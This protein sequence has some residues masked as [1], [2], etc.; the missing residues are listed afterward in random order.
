[1]ALLEATA[2]V[3]VYFVVVVDIVIAVVVVNFGVVD[4][5]FLVAQFVV[6]DQVIFSC[7]QYMLI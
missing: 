3:V 1:M 5:I 7:G 6:T 4:N 2:D